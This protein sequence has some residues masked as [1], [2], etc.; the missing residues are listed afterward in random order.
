MIMKSFFGCFPSVSIAGTGWQRGCGAVRKRRMAGIFLYSL[1]GVFLAGTRGWAIGS[2]ANTLLLLH[3]ENTANGAADETPASSSAVAYAS[4]VTGQALLL[5]DT[6]QLEYPVA[7]NFDPT[8]GSLEFWIKP[9]WAG[10]DNLGHT[11]LRHGVAGGVLVLKDGVNNLR[12]IFN[13]FAANGQPEVG[14]AY[15]IGAWTANSW[16]HVAFTWGDGALSLFTDG[17]ARASA[18]IGAL[19]AVPESTFQIGADGTNNYA[20]AVLDELRISS[21]PRT[22]AEVAQGYAEDIPGVTSISVTPSSATIWATWR[23]TPTVQA[24]TGVG[25]I[26]VPPALVSWVNP[27][28]AVVQVDGQGRL[29][30]LAKGKGALTAQFRGQ[31]V[32]FA[33]TVRA[34]VRPPEEL[35]IPTELATPRANAIYDM[36]VVIL[37]YLPTADGVN[38]DTTETG[39][40][41]ELTKVAAAKAKIATMN[42]Q[43][44]FSLSEGSR[45]RGYKNPSARPSLGYRVVKN[46]VVYEPLPPGKS[47]G[48]SAT[49]A[50]Y[51]QILTRFG[52]DRWVMAG[53]VKEV[54]LWGYH[55]ASIV[56]AESNMSSPT[57]GDISNS[58]RFNDDLPVYDRTYVLYN[59]NYG[60]SQNEAV[61][62][63]GHQLEAILSH[64]CQ[65]QDGNDGLFWNSFCG[66]SNGA[67]QAGRCGNTHFPPNAT[68]DYDY[69]RT[70][71][72]LSDC[73]DWRPDNSGQKKSVSAR[74]WGSLT[75]AWPVVPAGRT[76]AQYY[77]YWMQ[78]MPG[79]QNG[80][81]SGD[82]VM[83][84]WW[85]FTADW[86]G[87]IRKSAGLHKQPK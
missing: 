9:S 16:H 30:G 25:T 24:V 86:D 69:S 12:V 27:A 33:L 38:L 72:V 71:P 7:G 31:T 39:G 4:G 8:R 79:F 13:R 23:T 55:T 82:E 2:D 46:I 51:H 83:R 70:A 45:F 87:A 63:H 6:A 57:T 50:D 35:A 54:W 21:R 73:E 66:R 53:N 58:Y 77:V 19:P 74:T 84:D 81:R 48:G 37:S 40:E 85:E 56:P 78:N 67:F 17:V 18:V 64:V 29:V 43:V 60:R 36:P 26:T 5:K 61:H 41:A 15:S 52:A 14:V 49:F 44:K 68:A 42:R 80:I 59:Y 65:L 3:F 20:T 1:L 32:P 76:E 22:A 47:D 34:P 75:Y 28:P 11:V 10:D 62:N